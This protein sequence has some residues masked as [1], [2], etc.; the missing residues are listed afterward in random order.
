MTDCRDCFVPDAPRNDR[1]KH[2]ITE[3]DAPRNDR[4]EPAL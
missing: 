2:T 1:E 4:R 3:E